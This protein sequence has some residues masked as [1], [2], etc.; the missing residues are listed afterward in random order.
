MSKT[1]PWPFGRELAKRRR[2]RELSQRGAA[3]LAGISEGRW[4]QLESGIQKLQG[5]EIP[6]KTK[7]R[8][9]V[10]VAEVV[11]WDPA[12]AL[13]LAFLPS[14]EALIA[15]ES[16]QVD[17]V[18]TDLWRAL[19]PDE[20]SAFISLMRSV[21]NGKSHAPLNDQ[22]PSHFLSA[23]ERGDAPR[24]SYHPVPREAADRSPTLPGLDG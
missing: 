7:P 6:I 14:D 9:V 20:R 2:Q 21:V 1:Q 19:T 4:R 17:P 15:K 22:V 18:P 16:E 8:T 3:K 23:E 24:T 10:A 5:N 11:Q 12:E 13:S